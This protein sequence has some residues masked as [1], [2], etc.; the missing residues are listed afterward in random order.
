MGPA[1]LCKYCMVQSTHSDVSQAGRARSA[2]NDYEELYYDSLLMLLVYYSVS[3]HSLFPDVR[4]RLRLRVRC[5]EPLRTLCMEGLFTT[6]PV[7][8]Y[9]A[10]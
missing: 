7:R 10:N 3:S 6:P 5:Q 4:S 9:F 1:L 2:R 8:K